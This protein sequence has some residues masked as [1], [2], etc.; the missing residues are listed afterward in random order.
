MPKFTN[1]TKMKKRVAIDMDEVMADAI[2]KL[3]RLYETEYQQKVD[4]E[5]LPGCYLEEILPEAHKGCIREFLFREDFFKDL[6]V[7]P[8]SQE[9]I[10]AMHD[11]YEIFIVTAAMEFPDS[12]AHKYRWL[13][14][15][16][17]FLHWKNFVFC[18]DKS[19][20]HADYLIDDHAK[21]LLPFSGEPIMY[22]SPHNMKDE[23]F[24]R[25][26]NW[27]EVADIFL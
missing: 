17:P 27:K 24:R 21:N 7:M 1:Q 18:G 12:L 11:R 5:R 26:N 9:V 22:T 3:I 2:S 8:D 20:I 13:Q 25:V 4:R 19:I 10:R 16:F 15:H 23:R 14:E 6:E